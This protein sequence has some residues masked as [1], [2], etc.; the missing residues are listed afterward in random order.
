MQDNNVDKLVCLFLFQFC[1]LYLTCNIFS[2]PHNQ[3]NN[4]NN[5]RVTV[6]SLYVTLIAS[7][8]F[9]LNFTAKFTKSDQLQTVYP[10]FLCDLFTWS[11]LVC[12]ILIFSYFLHTYALPLSMQALDIC[13]LHGYS[14]FFVFKGWL[15]ANTPY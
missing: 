15:H 9:S 3:M 4:N 7:F 2:R 13:Y 5:K 11:Y 10:Y 12:I 1:S 8:L 14:I 6:I